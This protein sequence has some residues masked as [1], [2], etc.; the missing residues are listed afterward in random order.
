MPK[1]K[2][3]NLTGQAKANIYKKNKKSLEK[4]NVSIEN[5]TWMSTIFA[6]YVDG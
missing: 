5:I 4:M 6:T 3:G 2:K 1:R